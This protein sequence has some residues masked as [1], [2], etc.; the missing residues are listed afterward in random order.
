MKTVVKGRPNPCLE[1]ALK[2]GLTW[3]EFHRDRHS[4]YLAVRN[5]GLNEQGEECAYT[6]LWLGEGTPYKLHIDHYRKKSIYPNLRF[7]WDN[8]FV[9]AKDPSYGAD[10]KDNHISGKRAATDRIYES[11]LSPLDN[12]LY[13][14]FW[15][16]QNGKLIPH[17][18]L[19]VKEKDIVKKTIEIFNLNDDKLKAKRQNVIRMVGHYKDFPREEIREWLKGVGFSFLIAQELA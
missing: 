15:C 8:L 14:K 13:E 16:Q 3:D 1:Q 18:N 10:F 2:D 4:D 6:G 7:D 17:P 9:A 19:S 11:I 5:Q 12:N